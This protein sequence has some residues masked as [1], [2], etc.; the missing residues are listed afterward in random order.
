MQ[1]IVCIFCQSVNDN[2][3]ITENGFNGCQCKIC[4][5][6]YISPRPTPQEV[7]NL[8]GHDNAQISAQSHIAP[9]V[10]KN[11]H[12]QHTINIIKKYK[13]S[14]S[15]LEIGAGGG[16][17]LKA[18]RNHSFE[19]FAIELNPIQA[20]HMQQK[21]LIECEQKLLSDQSFGKKK[22]DVIYHCDVISHLFDPIAS[23]HIMYNKLKP[24]GLLVFET[25][26]IADINPAY[27]SY[28]KQFQYPDHLFFFGERTIKLLLKKTNFQL[29]KIYEYNIAPQL[30]LMQLRES[31]KKQTSKE[32]A[33]DH[34]RPKQSLIKDVYH[35]GMHTLRYKIG[36]WLPKN[37]RPQTLI[38]V[39]QKN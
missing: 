11:L 16:H 3:V 24:G 38:I 7:M 37:E 9:S 12:A 18:A 14:G 22:F 20:E 23:F 6:I 30:K 10:L 29:K 8:Y 31:S 33:S 36:A 13:T 5:L 26:N 2:V 27:F 17:F 25:G 32:K 35:Y 21:L 34:A 39:A 1:D 4:K 15:L 19:P 28:F